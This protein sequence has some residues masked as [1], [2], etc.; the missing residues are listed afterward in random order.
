MNFTEVV[1]FFIRVSRFVLLRFPCCLLIAF[2][3]YLYISICCGNL[4]YLGKVYARGRR[5]YCVG[6]DVV[7]A[8]FLWRDICRRY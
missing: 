3:Y 5:I 8:R 7:L 6:G 4:Q 2:R 1:Y